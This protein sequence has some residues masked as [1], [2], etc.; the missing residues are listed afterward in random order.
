MQIKEKEKGELGIKLTGLL[1]VA[2]FHNSGAI[3]TDPQVKE[4]QR[5]CL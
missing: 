4:H 5:L 3:N 2:E 1:L